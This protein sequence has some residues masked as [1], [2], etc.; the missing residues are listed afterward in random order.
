MCCFLA[1]HHANDT[2]DCLIIT[3]CV[4]S[5]ISYGLDIEF[6]F[7]F[8]MLRKSKQNRDRQMADWLFIVQTS[9][10]HHWWF[11]VYITKSLPAVYKI[12]LMLMIVTQQLFSTNFNDYYYQKEWSIESVRVKAI[13]SVEVPFS[14]HDLT[15][16][17]IT[18]N[19][20]AWHR[21][22]TTNIKTYALFIS[23]MDSLRYYQP[24]NTG[25]RDCFRLV[26]RQP[27]L[28]N[29]SVEG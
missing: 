23:F 4:Y 2:E 7:F 5:C 20:K 25:Y 1:K 12:F 10:P 27:R 14:G 9:P 18:D 24:F 8:F 19:T 21:N 16:I 15:D 11:A 6:I 26:F 3:V 28:P 13:F 17:S 29:W 22:F